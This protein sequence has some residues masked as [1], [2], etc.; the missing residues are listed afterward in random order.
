MCV[1]Y[2]A[3]VNTNHHLSCVRGCSNDGLA[4]SNSNLTHVEPLLLYSPVLCNSL[5][6]GGVNL[7]TEK[8]LSDKTGHTLPHHSLSLPENNS[9]SCLTLI[10]NTAATLKERPRFFKDCPINFHFSEMGCVFPL[11]VFCLRYIPSNSLRFSSL[12]LS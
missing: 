5:S 8:A 7:S 1:C 9:L 3:T 11:L 2:F 12:Y 10:N 4:N 6:E